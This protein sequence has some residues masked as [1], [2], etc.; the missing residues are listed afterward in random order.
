MKKNYILALFLFFIMLTTTYFISKY[1][2]INAAKIEKLESNNSF[3]IKEISKEDDKYYIKAYMPVT[4]IKELD[5][6]INIKYQNIIDKFIKEVYSLNLL[7]NGKKFSLNINFNSYEYDKYNSFLISY[8]CDFGGAH[9][10]T[11][12]IT[13]NYDFLI[14][15]LQY[16]N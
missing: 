16:I 1:S 5:N 2:V 12:I 10:D 7:E 6:K 8:I 3:K 4:N 13:I 14:D 9:P 11:N 15:Y